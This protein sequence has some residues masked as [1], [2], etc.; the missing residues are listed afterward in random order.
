[1]NRLDKIQLTVGL[2]VLVCGLGCAALVPIAKFLFLPGGF[3]S[4]AAAQFSQDLATNTMARQPKEGM[5]V[6]ASQA[7]QPCKGRG[8]DYIGGIDMTWAYS[9]GLMSDD[10][11]TAFYRR[12]GT[13]NGWQMFDFPATESLRGFDD[14]DGTCVR[15]ELTLPSHQIPEGRAYR[16]S[17]TY[18][19]LDEQCAA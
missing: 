15:F 13:A 6:V 12:Q 7:F 19:T 9:A 5:A 18:A 1:M 14:I 17:L 10:E 2:T 11:I 4:T 16:I 8:S 3:C